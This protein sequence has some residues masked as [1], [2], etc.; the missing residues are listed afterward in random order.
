MLRDYWQ[1]ARANTR[2]I[3]FGFLLAFLSSAGQTYFIGVFGASIQAEFGL[4]SGSWGRTYMVGTLASAFL[5][6]WSGSLI[7]RV[8]LR[9]FTASVLL[10]LALA[11]WFIASVSSVWMLI[12]AIFGLRHFGQG[13]TSHA[14]I[15]SMARY[16]K[17]DRGKAI[18]LA[19]IGYAVGEALLPVVGLLASQV[20]GWRDTFR[21]VGLMVLLLTPCALWLLRGHRERHAAHHAELEIKRD[22]DPRNEDYSRRQVLSEGRFYMMLPAMIAPSMIGTALFFFPAEIAEAKGWSS[23]WITGH[24]WL[25]SVVS[26]TVTIYSGVWIDRYSACRSFC[27]R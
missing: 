5:I 3:G 24:Y 19:A 4:D 16:H 13:L 18:A 22:L 15:T 27:C 9:Y 14:G 11:C 7:D 17:A 12:F 26:V 6:N 21:L 1:F 23:I 2:F 25:F 8:D 10:G 20:W